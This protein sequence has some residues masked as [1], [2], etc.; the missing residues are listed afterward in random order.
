MVLWGFSLR[1]ISSIKSKLVNISQYYQPNSFLIKFC[2]K[3]NF[4]GFNHIGNRNL[5]AFERFP[6]TF[7]SVS[8]WKIHLV[9]FCFRLGWLALILLFSYFALS[10]C[11]NQVSRF[12]S[13]PFV[14]TMEANY[15]DWAYNMP[16]LTICSDYANETFIRH[17]YQRSENITSINPNSSVYQDYTHYM[18]LIG[19][20]NAENI[21]SIN[22]F[23]HTDLFKSLSGEELFDIALNVRFNWLQFYCSVYRIIF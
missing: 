12:V 17:Y 18:K 20:L 6:F 3:T 13:D 8:A 22:E 9:K 21:H 15:R 1:F 5:T 16:A 7:L 2:K 4:H 14:F 23:E 10:I 11:I 19:S